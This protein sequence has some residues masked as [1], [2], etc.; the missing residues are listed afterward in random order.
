LEKEKRSNNVPAFFVKEKK[1]AEQGDVTVKSERLDRRTLETIEFYDRTA[2]AYDRVR[3]ASEFGAYVNWVQREVLLKLC[4]IKETKVLLDLGGGTGRFAV[5]FAKKCRD[6]INLDSS[7]SMLR[8]AK[9]K[10]IREKTYQNMHL[11]IA[12][13]HYLPFRK[14]SIDISISINV[15]LHIPDYLGVIREV[16]RVLRSKG[17]LVAN[18]P[19]IHSIPV[20]FIVQILSHG[21]YVQRPS[22]KPPHRSR[23]P[24]PRKS[25]RV[26]RM[27]RPYVR[28]FNIKEMCGG[29]TRAG[30]KI[31]KIAGCLIM[32]SPPYPFP[33]KFLPIARK[34]NRLFIFLPVK[35]ASAFLFVKGSKL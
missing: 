4:D 3:F 21:R 14:N 9:T 16:A 35:Y 6:V 25:K 2:D 18:F 27:P 32:G 30:L 15:L 11:I 20:N 22:G 33:K 12:E 28:W 1:L 19:N 17:C 7:R 31:S 5:E 34:L 26:R 13:G 29:Y 8:I 24:R 23:P 10:A